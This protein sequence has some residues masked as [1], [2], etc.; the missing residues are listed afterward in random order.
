[1]VNFYF[2]RPG[3]PVPKF[4]LHIAEDGMGSYLGVETP[5]PSPYPG[6]STPPAPIDR[7]FMLSAATAGKIFGLTHELHNF[8]VTCSSK[9]KNIADTGK[10]TLMYKGPGGDG[11]CTYNYS[12]NKNVMQLTELLLA[13]AET[14]DEGRR[15]DH[16]HRYDRLGLDAALGVLAEQ[17]TEGRAVELGT[18]AP[19][20]H[21]IAGDTEVMQRARNRALALLALIPDDHI[22]EPVH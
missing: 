21:A 18:I 6:V 12:D 20:L 15:L 8:N 16:L 13:I 19:T 7:N 2:E 3:L 11:V 17:V 5:P 9:A 1:M 14:M 10:K 22:A 4:S